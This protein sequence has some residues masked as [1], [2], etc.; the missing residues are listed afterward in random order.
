[1]TYIFFV[2]TLDNVT[3]KAYVKGKEE[4]KQIYD[5]AVSQGASAGYVAVK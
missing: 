5:Q 2:R 1:M 4:A 3:Y